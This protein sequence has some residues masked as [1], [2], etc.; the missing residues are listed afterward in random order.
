MVARMSWRGLDLV[1]TVSNDVG[2]MDEHMVRWHA[3]MVMRHV[4][5]AMYMVHAA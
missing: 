4:T 2:Q 3:S 1:H 5:M